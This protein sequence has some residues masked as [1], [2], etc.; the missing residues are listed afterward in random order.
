M[1]RPLLLCLI[2]F[3]AL[4]MTAPLSLAETKTYKPPVLKPRPIVA[5]PV[6]LNILELTSAEMYGYGREMYLRKNFNEAAKVFLQM[7]SL[8]CS[9]KVA[10]YHL[11]KIAAEVPSLA[12]LNAK[13]DQ[14]PCKPYDFTKEDFLPASIYYEKD[15]ALM[16]EQLISY[17]NRYRLSEKE[18][19]EKID[20]YIV[21]V[22]E[23]EATVWMLKRETP[24]TAESTGAWATVS[25]ETLKRVEQ[26]R[27]SAQKIEKEITFLKNQL[28]SERLD[29][30]K[31]VQDMRTGLAGAEAETVSAKNTDAMIKAVEQAKT[32]LTNKEQRLAEKDKAL[33]T[34]QTRFD[35]IQRRLK[36]IQIELADRNTQIQ[37][38]EANLQDTPKP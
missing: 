25:E 2:F 19:T 7:L 31:E 28:A 5:E 20:Q 36:I 3:S 29:G 17:K 23:L 1:E 22:K 21:M 32:E 9:N 10:Q 8:N 34:L 14:L 35:E 15:P 18:M 16:L 4:A 37:T 11:R 33:S 13:L 24:L 26:G 27:K 6:Q 12:F 30:Q 38:I